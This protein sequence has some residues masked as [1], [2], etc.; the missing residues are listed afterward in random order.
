MAT[1]WDPDSGRGL[2]LR[3]SEPGVQVYTGGYLG[4]SVVGKGKHPY[5]Q[6]AG[7]TFE[8]QKFPGSPNFSHFP[9]TRLDPG[10]VYEQRRD[11]QFFTR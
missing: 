5:C 8:T 1:L 2:T 4:P 6:Y 7:V 11:I 10:A 9:S 3:S